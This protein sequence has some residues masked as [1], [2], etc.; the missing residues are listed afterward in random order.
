MI[1]LYGHVHG[2]GSLAQVTRGFEEALGGAR[3]ATVPLDEPATLEGGVLGASAKHGVFTARLDSLDALRLNAAHSRRWV[4]V[5]PNS[6]QIGSRLAARLDAIATDVMTPSVWGAQVLK[7][8]LTVPVTVVPHGV[9][10]DFRPATDRSRLNEAYVAGQFRVEH[11]SSTAYGRKGTHELILGW[12]VAKSRSWLPPAATLDLI[13]DRDALMTTQV[14]LINPAPE[15]AQIRLRDRHG[16][17]GSGLSPA[18]MALAYQQAHLVIQPSRGE[19]FGLVPL[20]ARACATPVAATLCTGH[21]QH[22]V[23][24]TPGVIIIEHGRM[25]PL[26]DLPGSTAPTV[27]PDA[28]A[29]AL[30]RAYESWPLLA[31]ASLAHALRVAE[32]WAWPESLRD[33]ITQLED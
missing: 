27:S 15:W 9:F 5:A 25:A 16:F 12:G 14:L 21:S 32:S 23:A 1:R 24:S 2:Y 13:L 30:K 6:D 22:M 26:D 3:V 7:S 31:D 10:A 33:W 17:F 11:Y 19:G 28:I 20:E 18:E 29:A 4:M 8:L